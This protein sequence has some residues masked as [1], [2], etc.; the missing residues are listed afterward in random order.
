MVAEGGCRESRRA[1]E[2]PPEEWLCSPAEIDY[3]FGCGVSRARASELVRAVLEL[4]G[5]PALFLDDK[6]LLEERLVAMAARS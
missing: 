5:R 6:P 3:A 1:L 4:A 2:D